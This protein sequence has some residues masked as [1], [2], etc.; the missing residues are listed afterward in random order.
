MISMKIKIDHIAK[1]EGHAGFVGHIVKGNVKKAQ[2][3]VQ[4]GARL[5]ESL[6]IGRSYEDA[7]VITSRICGLCPVVHMIASIKALEDAFGVKPSKE[8][9]MLR[10]LMLAGQIIQSN[11]LHIFFLSATDFFKN[12]DGLD[13]AKEKP[14]LVKKILKLRDFGNKVIETVGGR[15]IHPLTPKVGG[16]HKI[17][18]KNVLKIIEK[19]SKTVLPYGKLLA[20]FINDLKIP[21]FNRKTSY[22]AYKPVEDGKYSGYYGKVN[23]SSGE[24]STDESFKNSISETHNKG[25]AVKTTKYEGKSYVT[26]AL[27]RIHINSE[28]LNPGAKKAFQKSGLRLPSYNPF[29]NILAQSIEVAH[30]IEECQKL[31]SHLGEMSWKKLNSDFEIKAGNGYGILEAPRGILYHHYEVGDKGVIINSDVITPTA[32]LLLNLNEDLKEY[33]SKVKN[34]KKEKREHEILKLVH[35]YDPCISCSVH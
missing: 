9:V 5:I 35:A 20:E 12:R 7:P 4:E 14:E 19:E 2:V 10:E 34:Y 18:S 6:L 25:D 16:W 15:A 23:S 29:Y 1:I 8:T 28:N 17:P 11:V 24:I 33:M 30:F 32:Q 3:E 26:D 27:A 21:A 22:I 13:L 31:S